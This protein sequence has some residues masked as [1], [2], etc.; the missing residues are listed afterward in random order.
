MTPAADRATPT[1]VVFDLG[2]VLLDWDP[3]R[4]YRKL[5]ADPE[6]RARFLTEVV[7]PSWHNRQDRGR[8]V[9]EG[10]AELI[11]AHPEHAELIGAYYG[12]WDEMTAGALPATVDVVREL[13]DAGVRLVALTNWPRETFEPAR[14]RF[15]FFQCFDGIVVSGAENMAKPD[16]EIF[17]LVL[18]RYDVDAAT[19][20]FVDDTPGHVNAARGVGMS[21]VVFT[22][23]DVL[24]RDLAALGL[25]VRADVSIRAGVAAD[26]PALTEIYNHYVLTTAV[27]FDLD[28]F[29]VERRQEWFG[30]YR[31]TGPYRLL[32]ATRGD[33]VIGYAT[34]SPFRDKAAYAPSIEVTAYLAA[35][36]GGAGVGSM[37]YQQ[38]LHDLRGEDLHRAYAAIALPNEASLALHRR[39]G[40]RDVGTMTEV[41]RKHGRWWDVL[42]ME[43]DLP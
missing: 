42:W 17:A 22:R 7:T 39:F 10:T 43:R 20:V 8:S 29:S 33:R 9:A 3:D 38:L 32:V 30:R 1:T 18:D 41:G 19:A 27:T 11:A 40:F 28:A 23:A 12:R 6:E 5:I 36:S 37:L 24:R 31:S 2:N 13:H 16:P 21:G 14:G 26:L 34:S 35:D 15:P 25:P 4:L